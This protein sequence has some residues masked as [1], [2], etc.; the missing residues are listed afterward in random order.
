[1]VWLLHILVQKIYITDHLFSMSPWLLPATLLSSSK[2]VILYASICL[3]VFRVLEMLSCRRYEINELLA[4]KYACKNYSTSIISKRAESES[5]DF[6]V[7]SS[8]TSSPASRSLSSLLRLAL[9]EGNISPHMITQRT[10]FRAHLS[11]TQ[12]RWTAFASPL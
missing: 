5:W 12:S 7:W 9:R 6:R 11:V 3:L 10:S 2:N 1:M 4:W 8:C